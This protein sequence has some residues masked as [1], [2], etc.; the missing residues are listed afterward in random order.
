MPD[1]IWNK[2]WQKCHKCVC[3]RTCSLHFTTLIVKKLCFTMNVCTIYIY[4]CIYA[5]KKYFYKFHMRQNVWICYSR[6]D[7]TKWQKHCRCNV[8][9]L[10]VL[11]ELTLI[12]KYHYHCTLLVFTNIECLHFQQ[13]RHWAVFQLRAVNC[14]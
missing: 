9:V 13:T 12:W 2:F 6:H 3:V 4:T 11:V 10:E 14:G 5:T 8:L 7:V 1:L